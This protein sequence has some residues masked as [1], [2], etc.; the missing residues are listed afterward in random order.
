[1]THLLLR[2]PLAAARSSGVWRLACCA[3]SGG[4]CPGKNKLLMNAHTSYISTTCMTCI[5]SIMHTHTHTHARAVKLERPLGSIP[6]SRTHRG[7][8]TPEPKNGCRSTSQAAPQGVAQT[9]R[10]VTRKL[11][12]LHRRIDRENNRDLV[13]SLLTRD[14]CTTLLRALWPSLPPGHLALWRDACC[15]RRFS[16]SGVYK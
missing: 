8:E 13:R 3:R 16:S 5:C 7:I 10:R 12:S 6:C 11:P 1:M 14:V 9:S 2:V 4:L 15:I